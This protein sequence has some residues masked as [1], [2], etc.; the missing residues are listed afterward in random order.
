MHPLRLPSGGNSRLNVSMIIS[1]LG[2]AV[3][4][5]SSGGHRPG[6]GRPVLAGPG[7]GGRSSPSDSSQMPNNCT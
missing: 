2:L 5:G 1:P 3:V 6:E 7:G 4:S